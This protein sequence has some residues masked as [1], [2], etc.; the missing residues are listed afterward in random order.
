MNAF[1]Y[2]IK[3]FKTDGCTGFPEGSISS[4]RIWHHC[5]IKHDMAYYLAGTI[6][7]R[8][9]ADLRLKQCVS[10]AAGRFYGELMYRGVVIGHYSPIKTSTRWGW[11]WNK[12]PYFET[13]N[14]EQFDQAIEGLY[15]SNADTKLITDFIKELKIPYPEVPIH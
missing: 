14:K 2:Q 15:K 1:G 7:D 13:L 6:K 12:R 10:K 8:S 11:A 9:Q 4:P 3:T 5:C